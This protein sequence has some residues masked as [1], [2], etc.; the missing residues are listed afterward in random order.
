MSSS[1]IFDEEATGDGCSMM[2]WRWNERI[3]V[4][5]WGGSA[6]SRGSFAKMGERKRSAIDK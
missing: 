1:V 4:S 3:M 5:G 6:S 2:L